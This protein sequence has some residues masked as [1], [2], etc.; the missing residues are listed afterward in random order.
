MGDRTAETQ[1]LT[2]ADSHGRALLRAEQRSKFCVRRKAF[3]DSLFLV[4]ALLREP[5]NITLQ[6]TRMTELSDE[7]AQTLT[8]RQNPINWRK[9]GKNQRATLLIP[10]RSLQAQKKAFYVCSGEKGGKQHNRLP[11]SILMQR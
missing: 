11:C 3:S 7:R 4:V 6:P 5:K 1:R 9:N 2:T 10:L 8:H